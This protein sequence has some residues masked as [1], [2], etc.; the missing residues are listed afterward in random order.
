MSFTNLP[1]NIIKTKNHDVQLEYQWNDD[2][3]FHQYYCEMIGLPIIDTIRNFKYEEY[4]SNKRTYSWNDNLGF[5]QYHC[6]L[7]DDSNKITYNY[8]QHFGFHQYHCD[9]KHI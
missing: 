3:G 2:F 6:N 4:D 1:A 5:H 7:G 9:L 8:N